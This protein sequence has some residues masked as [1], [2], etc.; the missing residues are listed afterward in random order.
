MTLP[1]GSTRSRCGPAGHTR[2]TT[3]AA[4]A[5]RL[6]PTH[7]ASRAFS[8]T[9]PKGVSAVSWLP[10]IACLRIAT[11]RSGGL[12]P[13]RIPTT[14]FA[15]ITTR[16]RRFLHA[17]TG[18]TDENGVRFATWTYDIHGTRE[19]LATM[20]A[21]RKRS[22]C[23]MAR[24]RRPP[25]RA[26]RRSSMRSEPRTLLLSGCRRR[27][28]A[29]QGRVTAMPGLHR[30]LH[31]LHVRLERQHVVSDR[32]STATRRR[33]Y[34]TSRAISRSRVPRQWARR[35]PA[36]PRRNGIPF[37]GCQRRSLR[38]RVLAASTK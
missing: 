10:A 2:S 33:M 6:S 1:A 25:T 22:T 29:S 26:A 36:P 21:A 24:I 37:I 8:L 7:P 11:T 13:S 18:I 27:C 19:F 3:M 30:R 23:T 5:S 17:L 15:P 28:S 35:S 31:R 4:A 38:H 16:T 20:R 9:M 34:S 32:T 12:S 14:P